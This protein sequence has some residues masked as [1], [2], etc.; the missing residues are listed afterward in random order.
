M[1]W[2]E[3][4][5]FYAASEYHDSHVIEYNAIREAAALIDV[6]P[7]FKYELRGPDAL[8]LVDRLITRDA[9]RLTPGRVFYTPWCDEHGKVIDDGTVHRLDDADGGQVIRWTAADPQYRWLRMNAH[10][11]DVDVEDV[12]E[13]E[14][15]IA[16]QGPLA[17]AVLEAAS[18]E[19]FGDLAY[20]RSR[21]SHLG[22][23]PVDV[24]RTG[25]TGDLGYEL[26]IP[27]GR[28]VEAWDV[29]VAAGE[30]YRIRPAGMV[31]LDVTRLEAGL[32]L[33]EVD[34]TSA[35]HS[36]IPAQN[37]SPYEI[38]LGRLVDF[39]K[40]DYVGKRALLAEVAAGGPARRLV[41]LDIAW[42]EIEALYAAEGL[43]PYAPPVVSRAHVPLHA[44]G[45]QVGRVTSTGWSP[46][47]KKMIALASVGVAEARTGARVQVEWTVEAR[48]K[49]VS[50]T[51][52]D[53]PFFDPPRK[54]A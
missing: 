31:A 26:W 44:S 32:V 33:I 9:T 25:Y 16:L 5:G 45:R 48:R 54:R 28:A 43:A 24:S 41:G 52:V 49:L 6:S 18:G 11:L 34:Y 35:V 42:T 12:S 7:L 22:G 17:R 14:A 4:S 23:I 8:R 2:R 37:F 39:A 36:H 13:R 53:L 19:P 15:A 21:A 10:G 51:V 50:A 47:L 38:G 40:A 20:F 29:L 46:L 3:W 1:Q 30:P 27:A